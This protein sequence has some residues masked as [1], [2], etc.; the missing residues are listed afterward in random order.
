LADYNLNTMLYMNGT[1]ATL[2]GGNGLA[3][4]QITSINQIYFLV[5]LSKGCASIDL[6]ATL[7]SATFFRVRNRN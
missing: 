7:D 6:L 5:L 1:H 2:C 3:K 4:Y